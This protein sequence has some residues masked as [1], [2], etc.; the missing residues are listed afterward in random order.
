MNIFILDKNPERNARYHVD[1]HIVKMPLETA[2]ILCT[3]MYIWGLAKTVGEIPYKPTHKNHPC[4]KWAAESYANFRTLTDIG[5][6]LCAEYTIRYNKVHAC[7]EVIK[8]AAHHTAWKV[9]KE[10]FDAPATPYAQAMPEEY[11]HRNSVTAYRAYYNGE[12]SHLFKW[13]KRK[14]PNWTL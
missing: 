5:K 9:P 8:M 1:R 2:Q 7:E 6:A 13:T 3:V 10:K 11:K 4:V 12:K 14:Q